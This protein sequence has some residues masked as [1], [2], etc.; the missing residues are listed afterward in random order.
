[1]PIDLMMSSALSREVLVAVP[2][3]QAGQTW[4]V[5]P[6]ADNRAMHMVRNGRVTLKTVERSP[7]M[8]GTTNARAVAILRNPAD[9][10][11]F[12][13]DYRKASE[14]NPAK[15]ADVVKQYAL[16]IF[17]ISDQ[18]EVETITGFEEKSVVLEPTEPVISKVGYLLRPQEAGLSLLLT[19]FTEHGVDPISYYVVADSVEQVQ[20]LRA[21]GVPEGRIVVLADP[22]EALVGYTRE[23]IAGD[24]VFVGQDLDQVITELESW[25]WMI[26]GVR[27][28]K[29]IEDEFSE[30]VNELL[31]QVE[32]WLEQ[33]GWAATE[34]L[35]LDLIQT[36]ADI[37]TMA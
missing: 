9:F 23:G 30:E 2:L 26:D 16:K 18:G 6:F 15:A 20:W 11:R 5:Q 22:D 3:V 24:N 14:E 21:H 27:D 8:G 29:P 33:I 12:M 25:L 35:D 31:V 17:Q 28:V 10:N 1:M 34:P 7:F 4:Y 37:N 13:R 19:Q 36:I 32:L